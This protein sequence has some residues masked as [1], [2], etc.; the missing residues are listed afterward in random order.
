MINTK[1]GSAR[2]LVC[3]SSVADKGAASSAFWRGLSYLRY[4][5]ALPVAVLYTSLG[6][7]Y[8][9]AASRTLGS[10][11]ELV[12]GI[13]RRWAKAMLALFNIRVQVDG[14]E[15]LP[16]GGAIFVFNHSSDFDIPII[17]AS[18]PRV[19]RFGA[20][21]ELF[22]VPFLSL[23]MRAG[24]VLPIARGQREEVLKVYGQSTPRLHRGTSFILAPEGTRQTTPTIGPFKQGPFIFAIDARVPV[25]PIVIEG[26]IDIMPKNSVWIM[27]GIWQKTVRVRFLPCFDSTKYGPERMLELQADVRS[28][29]IENYQNLRTPVTCQV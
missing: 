16:Q 26:A 11:T 6:A 13:F 27:W 10:D 8:V 28:A 22:K 15:N 3:G 4:F 21:A 1:I 23:A 19:G 17:W 14:I 12:Q 18:L 20:K 24:G 7:V 5:F 25:A 2:P 9:M 29:M